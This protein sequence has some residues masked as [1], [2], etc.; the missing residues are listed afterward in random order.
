M[1]SPV[2]MIFAALLFFPLCAGAGGDYL[3]VSAAAQEE[4]LRYLAA[5]RETYWVDTYVSIMDHVQSQLEH[6]DSRPE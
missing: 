1:Q 2:R 3:S 6:S 4:L 5:N